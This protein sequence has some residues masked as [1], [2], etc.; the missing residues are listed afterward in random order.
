MGPHHNEGAELPSSEKP[1]ATKAAIRGVVGNGSV[2]KRSQIWEVQ[3]NRLD[4]LDRY[5]FCLGHFRDSPIDC[6]RFHGAD[7]QIL[8]KQHGI[9]KQKVQLFF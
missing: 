6:Y 5:I 1:K 8:A 7:G 2:P 4:R 3:M 9:V